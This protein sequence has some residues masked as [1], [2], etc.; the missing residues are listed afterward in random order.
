M[1]TLA[2]LTRHALTYLAGLLAA[3]LTL[4]L[5]GT[6]LEAAKQAAQAL[7]EPLVVLAGFVAVILVRLAMPLFKNI[8]P[9]GMDKETGSAG[10]ASGGKLPLGLLLLCGTLAGI[11]GCLPACSNGVPLRINLTG[12]DGTASYSSKGG[13]AV[14]YR[15][16]N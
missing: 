7:I 11:M 4:H 2:T 15:T 14:D 1:K 16:P 9:D 3:W 6:D 13:L 12:P 5:T 8:F 10:G